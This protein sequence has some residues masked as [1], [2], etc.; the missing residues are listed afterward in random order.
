MSQQ[1]PILVV[2]TA[3]R[4]SFVSALDEAKLFP[5]IETVWADAARAIE[6]V[7]PAAVIAAAA[8]ID[9]TSLA[10]LAA[11][12]APRQPYLPLIAVDPQISLPESVIP[13]F[14]AQ[15]SPGRLVARLRA[16]LR[17]RALHATVMRRLVPSVP[18]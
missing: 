4:P 12:I 5:V 10:M 14:Q 11:R 6:Q 16:A 13:F 8:G 2:S 17:A 1:G 15:G 18:F 3:E 7:Q 9:E